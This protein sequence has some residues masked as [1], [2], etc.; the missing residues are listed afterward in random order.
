MSGPEFIVCLECDSPCYTFEWA[1]GE[2]ADPFC[3]MCGNDQA[4]QF[5]TEEDLEAL[6]DDPQS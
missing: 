3:E 6:A 5:I 4:D 2:I 1:E